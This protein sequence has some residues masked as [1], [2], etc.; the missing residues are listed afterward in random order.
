MS[1]TVI[2]A[3]LLLAASIS[4]KTYAVPEKR[5][6]TEIVR[7]GND[8]W[9][10][11][12]TIDRVQQDAL[13]RPRLHAF[14]GRVT[15][16]GRFRITP[17]GPEHQP[18]FA[19]HTPD[20]A[21]WFTDAAR[22]T[23][24][25]IG[26]DGRITKVPAS[27]STQHIV[28]AAGDLWCSH[29]YSGW[30][31]RHGLDGSSKGG[32]SV[33][34][35]LPPPMTS[36]PPPPPGTRVASLAVGADGAIW[37]PEPYRKRIGRLTTSGEMTFY[38]V[39]HEVTAYS[40]IIAGPDGALWYTTGEKVLGRITLSGEISSVPIGFTAQR[41]AADSRGRLWYTLAS[42]SAGV[43]ERDGTRREFEVPKVRSIRSMAEG[44]DGAMWIADDNQSVIA[45]IELPD[46]RV[47]PRIR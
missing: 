42:N 45:R 38:R 35:E 28:Y 14:L 12:W 21:L 7:H 31:S 5:I 26:K 1:G 23:F 34:D 10:V 20:G 27:T 41:L 2:T 47:A 11:A 18:G 36:L 33:P 43:I 6:P 25:R 40:V 8:L 3:A 17:A 13:G 24:W 44:P 46:A 15:T 16:R 37:F 39:P 32:F 4:V 9:F 30:I 19:T 22:A 29:A